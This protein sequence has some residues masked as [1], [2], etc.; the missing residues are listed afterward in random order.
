MNEEY[1]SNISF[2]VREKNVSNNQQ[3]GRAGQSNQS[4]LGHSY[5]Q[6]TSTDQEEKVI[7]DLS[8]NIDHQGYQQQA[9]IT[10]T[11]SSPEVNENFMECLGQQMTLSSHDDSGDERDN[12]LYQMVTDNITIMDQQT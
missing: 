12:Q 8:S 10:S 2:K 11:N 7:I 5:A 6:E 9:Q 3:A 1:Q 4:G